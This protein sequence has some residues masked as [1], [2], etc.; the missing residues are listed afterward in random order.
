MTDTTTTPREPGSLWWARPRKLCVMER[1]GGG[2]RSHR[3]ARREAEIAW[4]R[5]NGVRRVVSTMTSRHNLAAYD[6]A[7]LE[8]FHLPFEWPD[9]GPE[10]LGEI[11]VALRGPLRR[12]GAMAIHANRHTDTVAAIAAGLLYEC[13]GTDPVDGLAAALS[14]G[15]DVTED[16]ADMLGVEW[17]AVR[18][19]A[20]GGLRML[21]A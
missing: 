4:L 12:G 14:A 1:P 10:R 8:A 16:C 18:F 2:G 21:S 3:P 17:E 20:D 5:D 6:E 9:A 15:L 13:W 11:I 19:W 7:G